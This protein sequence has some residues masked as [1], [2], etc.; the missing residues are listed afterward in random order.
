MRLLVVLD[1]ELRDIVKN[2]LLLATVLLPCL[3]FAVMPIFMLYAAQMDPMSPQELELLYRLEPGLRGLDAV[4]ASQVLL[5]SQTMLVFL[6]IPAIVP[7]VIAS[8]SII[9]EKQARSL[10]PLL[11][12]PVSVTELLAGKC[13]GAVLPAMAATWIGYLVALAGVSVVG[14]PLALRATLSPVWIVSMFTLAPALCLT[15]VGLAVIVSSRVNDTRV[16]QQV[17]VLLVLPLIA[18]FAGQF[19]GQLLVSVNTVLLATLALAA[20]DVGLFY[21][22]VRLFRRETIL[23]EWR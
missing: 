16:A 17:S 9:G 13:L 22:A 8:F 10:E 7:L 23:T 21:V 2:R 20:V 14:T 1:K 6:M 5:I 4:T 19:S 11:A 12:T 3:I 18:L 15:A